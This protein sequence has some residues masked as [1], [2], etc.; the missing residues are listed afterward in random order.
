MARKQ[1]AIYLCAG[2]EAEEKLGA[3]WRSNITPFLKDLNFEVWNPCEFEPEQL[4]G[5]K[6]NRLPDFYTDRKTG[7]KVVPT[8][9]HELKMAKEPQFFKRFA[10]YMN[11]IR[12]YDIN[13]INRD[14]DILLVYW[15]E[16][17]G[18]GAGSHAEI[19]AAYKKGIPI[20]IVEESTMPAW[21]VVC[22]TELFDDFDEMK[23][24]LIEEYGE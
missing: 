17:T 4:K 7:K 3:G 13:L 15:N 5:L 16:R 19:E 12:S 9:W 20:Y 23:G 6:P 11:R 2:M 10:T 22:A 21:L 8:H 24:F 14:M 1:L 18:R